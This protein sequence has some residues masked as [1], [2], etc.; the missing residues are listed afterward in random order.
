MASP[1]TSVVSFEMYL[2]SARRLLNS[3]S[4]ML[5]TPT[6]LGSRTVIMGVLNVTP[7]SFPHGGRFRGHAA[8]TKKRAGGINHP[9]PSQR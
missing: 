9:A 4:T 8:A 3:G 6:G 2:R 5:P 7:D 1:S